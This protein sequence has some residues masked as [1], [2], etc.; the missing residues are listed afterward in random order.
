MGPSVKSCY[1]LT[2]PTTYKTAGWRGGEG[3]APDKQSTGAKITE[4]G[5]RILDKGATKS[6]SY[7]SANFF[8]H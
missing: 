1:G 8:E 2:G 3:E 5:E 6:F 4:K 7:T